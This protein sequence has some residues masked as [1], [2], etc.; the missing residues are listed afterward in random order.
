[1]LFI[2]RFC[3]ALLCR[4]KRLQYSAQAAGGDIS[5][6][7]TLHILS[8]TQF[9]ECVCKVITFQLIDLIKIVRPLRQ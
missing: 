8:D 6:R 5:R 4:V 7:M 3:S 2:V 9:L 1:M